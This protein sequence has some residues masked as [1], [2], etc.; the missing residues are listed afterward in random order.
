MC[1]VIN[2]WVM[3]K[4]CQGQP[5]FMDSFSP[6][7]QSLHFLGVLLKDCV[8]NRREAGKIS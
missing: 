5:C 1:N 3:K 2:T 4:L 6:G 8:L 7:K